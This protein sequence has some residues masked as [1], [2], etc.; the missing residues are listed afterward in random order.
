MGNG[1][2][3]GEDRLRGAR[4]GIG[5]FVDEEGSTTLAAAVAVLVSLALV[6]GMATVQWTVA[7]SADVQAVADAGALAG[8]NVVA[9]YATVAQ[10]LD[11]LV[12]SMGLIGM[13]T[14]AIGLVLSAIPGVNAAGPPVLRA[15]TS[16]FNARAKLSQTAATGLSRLEKAVPYLVAANSFL[17]VRANSGDGGSYVG[18]AIAYPNEGA[19]DFGTLQADTVS[20][21][22]QQVQDSGDEIDALAEQAAAAETAANEAL[23]RGWLADC[24]GEPSMR[25]RAST[26][27]GLE[28]ALNPD[29]PSS[30]GWNF[31]VPILRARAYYQ[32]RIARE[33]PLDS[34]VAELSRSAARKAFYGYALEL[35]NQ[36]SYWE[37]E[38][39]T[40]TCDLKEL[41]RNTDDVRSTHLYTD[42]VWPCTIE[43]E[44]PTIHCSTACPGADGPSL[45]TA[46]LAAEEGG[47][48]RECPVCAFTVV[49]VGR[50]PSASTSI[51]NGFEYHWRAVVEASR[52]YEARRAEQSALE[53]EAR[54]ASD[55]AA[56]LFGQALE[57]LTVVRVELCPPGRYG[58]VCVVAAPGSLASPD[59]L[60]NALNPGGGVPARAAVSAAVL[61]R[62]GA[63]GNS[64]N[65]AN[66]FDGLV[67]QG[68][69][70][71][72]ASFVLDAVMSAWG[73]LL[74]S[75]DDGYQAF[76]GALDSAFKGLAGMGM[77]GV[78]SWLQGALEDA[79]EL[80]GLQPADMSSKKPVLVNSQRVLARA[81]N[82]WST[83]VRALVVAVQS[84]GP[85]AGPSDV[86]GALGVFVETLNGSDK[87]VL[88]E[89]TIPG[90]DIGIP[91]ELDLGWLRE[92][93]EAA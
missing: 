2:R 51:D 37:N 42:A 45:G 15:A 85:S 9:A 91:L 36:S 39:G 53:S 4:E 75:Y 24:G 86:L 25:E 56:D 48:V 72:G 3:S 30:S 10:V 35:V 46:S 70:V 58:C 5:L 6:F 68:G 38:D 87:L 73:N 74:V 90:T 41:P 62:D 22:A 19:S 77:T 76:T 55:E 50:A 28:G 49:D 79:V 89:F 69:V 23:E 92:V 33:A 78:S 84:V 34:S 47:S 82:D 12:L 21:L 14:L 17:A 1:H 29:Y 57:R 16:V 65:L 60:E 63:A 11:A 32:Q 52:D 44:G 80:T 27:A 59:A 83:L 54:A 18:V 61:A 93:G 71:G 7:R 67:A 13:L 20:D 64:N 66:L 8:M 43:E 26:L 40:V 88:G 81:G 31:G